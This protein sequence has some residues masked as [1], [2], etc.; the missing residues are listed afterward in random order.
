VPN[1]LAIVFLSASGAELERIPITAQR[2]RAE[3][4]AAAGSV[5]VAVD[6]AGPSAAYEID[7]SFTQSSV[8]IDQVSPSSGGSGTLVSISGSGFSTDAS[9]TIVLFGGIAGRT[10][11]ST[12]T[13]VT[14]IV[15]AHAVD[16]R[17][18]VI[19]A[20]RRVEGPVFAVGNTAPVPPVTYRPT[21]S[22]VRFDPINRLDLNV[23]VL[24]VAFDPAVTSTTV[25]ALAASVGA[26]VIGQDAALNAYEFEFGANESLSAIRA[27]RLRL[28]GEPGVLRVA[29]DWVGDYDQS[30]DARDRSGTV[31]DNLPAGNAF[32]KGGIF[33]AL[34][35]IRSTPPWTH[36]EAFHDV[37]VAVVDT[38]FNP[39]AE[40]EFMFGGQTIVTLFIAD[41]SGEFVESEFRELSPGRG[42][43]EKYGHGTSVTSVIAAVNNGG[44]APRPPISGVLNSVFTPAERPFP[45]LVYGTTNSAIAKR[46]AF[47]AIASRTGDQAVDVVNISWRTTHANQDQLTADRNEWAPV[48][49]LMAGR[50]LVVTAAGNGGS[51]AGWSLPGAMASTRDWVVNV[52]ATETDGVTRWFRSNFDRGFVDLATVGVSVP[53]LLAKPENPDADENPQAWSWTSGTSLSA[54]QVAGLAALL[55]AMRSDL[56]PD[57]LKSVLRESTKPVLA[58]NEHSG[59]GG[60][61]MLL[62]QAGAAVR[63][64]LP[65]P[66]TQPV[67]IA[68]QAGASATSPGVIVALELDPMTG[69]RMGSAPFVDTAIPLTFAKAGTTFVGRNPG[70]MTVAP[71]GDYLYV[72][73][74]SASAA[75]GDGLLVVNTKNNAAEDFIAFSGAPFPPLPNQGAPS[76][77]RIADNRPAMVISRDGRLAYA[78]AG[79]AL[80]VINLVER[81]IVRT[82]G[83]L[84]FEYRAL[85]DGQEPN[86]VRE[87][88]AAAQ[89]AVFSGV[90]TSIGAFR[91]TSITSLVLSPDGKTLFAAFETGGASGYQPGGVVALNVD[92]YSDAQPEVPGLQPN[93][94]N[95]LAPAFANQLVMSM[96]GAGQASGGD[97]P[98]G[99]AI[100]QDGKYLYLVNGGM[101]FFTVVP[102]SELHPATYTDLIGGPGFGESAALGYSAGIN[103]IT[104]AINTSGHRA[105]ATNV[106]LFRDFRQLSESGVTILNAPGFTGVFDISPS[107]PNRGRQRWIFPP[108]VVTGWNP[109]S[110]DFGLVVN[111]LS[112]PDVYGARPFGI[113]VR[114]DG[115][116]AIMPFFQTGNFAILDLD[117]QA[118]FRNGPAANPAFAAQPTD[119]FQAVVGVTPSLKLTPQIW[120]QRGAYRSFGDNF[121]VPSPDERLLFPWAIAYAQSG[122]FAVATHRGNRSAGPPQPARLPD[123]AGSFEQRT[124]LIELGYSYDPQQ[125]D[126]ITAPDGRSLQPGA[127]VTFLP[128]GGAISVIR[129]A[130]I[131]RNFQDRQGDT[132]A[133]RNDQARPWF[134]TVPFCAS[135]RDAGGQLHARCLEDVV[136]H[137][138]DYHAHDA[139]TAF[140]RPG[141]VAIYPYLAFHTPRFGDYVQLATPVV[142]QW[143]DARVVAL[144]L[145]ISDL[146]QLDGNG[147]PIVQN[148]QLFPLGQEQLS[149]RTA[150][151]EFAALFGDVT[152]TQASPQPGHRYRILIR[153]LTGPDPDNEIELSTTSVDV[154]FES[155]ESLHESRLAL[156]P[157]VGA[158]SLVGVSSPLRL[159]ARFTPAGPSDTQ[160]LDV[161][162]SADT[163]YRST[164]S[165]NCAGEGPLEDSRLATAKGLIRNALT[166]SAGQPVA[167]DDASISITGG[168]TSVSSPGIQLVEAKHGFVRSDP[169]V[170]LAGFTIE[171]IDLEPI[172][173][174]SIEAGTLGSRVLAAFAPD[175]S[176]QGGSNNAPIVIAPTDSFFVDD[177]GQIVL[178]RVMLRYSGG[179]TINLN[180]LMAA[181]RPL[182]SRQFADAING[183]YAPADNTPTWRNAQAL[184]KLLEGPDTT[185]LRYTLDLSTSSTP[186]AIPS[187]FPF[188]R[189]R[190]SS[191]TAGL[192]IVTGRLN[193]G[194]F[195]TGIDSVLVWSLPSLE[196]VDVDPPSLQI[197]RDSAPT[198]GPTLRAIARTGA[199]SAAV[200]LPTG[201]NTVDQM[202]AA[203]LPTGMRG[204]NFRRQLGSAFRFDVSG[205]ATASG[206]SLQLTDFRL[207]F[208]V[209]NDDGSRMQ[210]TWSVG[211]PIVA[212][213]ATADFEQHIVH[214]NQVGLT[215]ATFALHIDGLGD[216]NGLAQIEVCDCP[217]PA[218]AAAL[219]GGGSHAPPPLDAAGTV[220]P[221]YGGWRRA[222]LFAPP[223][224]VIVAFRRE[225]LSRRGPP[226]W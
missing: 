100:S 15:P 77:V 53:V 163:C 137:Y 88:L 118:A 110:D 196:S 102:P 30:I 168:L 139:T 52:G 21:T 63:R 200:A 131:T 206:S 82:L 143:R 31:L 25:D 185:D 23:S 3:R 115:R 177:D 161:T 84:P 179:G 189:A 152:V 46:K 13:Q 226:R 90:S 72:V 14:A 194:G 205:N 56:T 74:S 85:A 87:R 134:A 201:Y 164:V 123:F 147:N 138:Y 218:P 172:V 27:L 167:F 80:V 93:L 48:L 212:L 149:Q 127:P 47:R 1:T 2:T 6:S 169:S 112:F 12:S 146:D 113:A 68:N 158:I 160:S 43:E 132:V 109:N 92:L 65:A 33:D 59:W 116:R 162:S 17:L 224:A 120:P 144:D 157:T 32:E 150:Q 45:A 69:H 54:P 97:E 136:D 209:P 70:S 105:S 79:T 50:T 39:I 73:V 176:P 155:N 99:L 126:R 219:F 35:T 217:S 114:P 220:G 44:T 78:G 130:P 22:V 107:S 61:G 203:A 140:A 129:D 180:D 122:R 83:D 210:S 10:V 133:I 128:G 18:V 96:T 222:R 117:L 95:Y 67:F 148:A 216:A 198:P 215:T 16:G 57:Q 208:D 142:L 191:G 154:L 37:T 135:N 103:G 76:A 60:T 141:G 190:F 192:A 34:T 121:T 111:H 173:E 159:Q 156:T 94:A 193:L 221:A 49:Q 202:L 42:Q 199:A 174:A 178:D 7:T 184:V 58:A 4:A 36:R 9:D 5:L 204:P 211:A 119:M 75:L 28:L 124:R 187:N 165:S 175:T 213:G 207:G 181:L 145:K 166:A 62:L 186:I 71:Q 223:D 188:F 195:G 89:L 225:P 106:Q 24:S 51:H 153:A 108:E 86:A 170:V 26:T 55:L 41:D 171:R 125:P 197:N 151:A 8:T 98:A 81:R 183:A 19:S 214:Q 104:S 66:T 182:I 20:T 64:L 91:G 38:G 29:H 40:D 101:T 11:S